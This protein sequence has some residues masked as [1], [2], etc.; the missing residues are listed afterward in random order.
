MNTIRTLA[1]RVALAA[2]VGLAAASLY[3]H[4]GQSH[5]ESRALSFCAASQPGVAS[6]K[7]MARLKEE[8]D[9]ATAFLR[10]SGVTVIYGKSSQYACDVRFNGGEV[11]V[12][13]VTPLD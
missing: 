7:V 13:S 2:C 11:A 4:V 5:A 10:Q 6:E 3:A 1:P 8:L 9:Q 12:A